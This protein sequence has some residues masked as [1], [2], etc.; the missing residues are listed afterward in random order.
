[1]QDKHAWNLVTDD[2]SWSGVKKI[3]SDAID[4]MSPTIKS[5]S[6]NSVV[7]FDYVLGNQNIHISGFKDAT[8][9]FKIGDAWVWTKY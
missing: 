1:M 9:T 4:D 3:L 8:G 2:T 7:N 6:N 5:A